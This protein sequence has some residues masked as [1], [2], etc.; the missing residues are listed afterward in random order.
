MVCGAWGGFRVGL[1]P[2]L[3][4]PQRQGEIGISS[5][6]ASYHGSHSYESGRF[7]REKQLRNIKRQKKSSKQISCVSPL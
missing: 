4:H 2:D 5:P 6:L 3:P 7:T 1:P